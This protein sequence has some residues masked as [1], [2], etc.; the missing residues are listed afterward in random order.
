M[1]LCV[2][3]VPVILP[4]MDVLFSVR[5]G[6]FTTTVVRSSLDEVF[7][8]FEDR[9]V[10]LVTDEHVGALLPPTLRYPQVILPPG[11]QGKRWGSVER[12]LGEGFSR[13]FGRDAVF[14]GVGGGA[15]TDV[16]AFAAS[17]YMR[18]IEVVL[19]PTTLLAMVDAALG[20]KTGIDF[21]SYKNMVGTFYPAREVRLAV[22]FVASL[23]EREYRSGLA[24]VIK[25]AMLGDE[26]LLR[27]LERE[28]ERILLREK[29]LVQEMVERAL[30]VKAEVV[31]SDFREGGRRAF[32]NLGHTFGHALE[33]VTGFSRFTHGEAVA[34]GIRCALELGSRLGL[35]DAAYAERITA[36]LDA[37]GYPSTVDG[38]ISPPALLEAMRMDKKKQRGKIRC[39]VQRR[40]GDTLLVDPEEAVLTE[41]VKR[42]VE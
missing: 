36:L 14:L 1:P 12:I 38:G 2:F 16:T 35:T 3:L 5:L 24:E 13:G 33:S 37:Y 28:R 18:G 10:L 41:I 9:D 34:W 30:R 23:P 39:V 11:E 25:S 7:S 32:L 20:G 26:D 15:V 8:G 17:L 22:P 42:F 31:E 27:V 4:S 29:A 21:L 40:M 6:E 19:V